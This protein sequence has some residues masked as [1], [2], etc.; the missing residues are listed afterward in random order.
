MYMIPR[1]YFTLDFSFLFFSFSYGL[2]TFVVLLVLGYFAQDI[3]QGACHPV[4]LSKR[5]LRQ[6]GGK[7]RDSTKGIVTLWCHQA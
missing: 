6:G 4:L 7:G 3:A 5:A 2:I 1:R